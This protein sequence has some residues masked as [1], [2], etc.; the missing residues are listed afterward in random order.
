MINRF[1]SSDIRCNKQTIYLGNA[2]SFTSSNIHLTNDELM[3]DIK[4]GSLFYDHIIFSAAFFWQNKV[5]T[6]L[7]YKLEEFILHGFV[8]P[9]IRNP[10]QTNDIYD[11]ILVRQEETSKEQ[12]NNILQ[13]TGIIDEI[14]RKEDIL[15]AKRINSFKSLIHQDGLSVRDYYKILYRQDLM[16]QID[17]DSLFS[18]I[19]N[20]AMAS[21]YEKFIK[22][23]LKIMYRQDFSRSVVIAELD[24]LRINAYIIGKLVK[25]LS[26]LFLLANSRV[27]N[28]DLMISCSQ[29]DLYQSVHSNIYKGNM[30]LNQSVLLNMGIA[31]GD[32]DVLHAKDI[33]AIKSSEE[34]Q[35]FK[36]TYLNILGL[37]KYQE[38]KSIETVIGHIAKKGKIHK[39][40]RILQVPFVFLKNFSKEVATFLLFSSMGIESSIPNNTLISSG[41]DLIEKII[42]KID[43]FSTSGI[44]DFADYIVKRKYEKEVQ[45]IISMIDKGEFH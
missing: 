28:S 15:I 2:D 29:K 32:I 33:I 1:F 12:D 43:F 21:K 17:P 19:H 37:V 35:K 25:R 45:I 3:R 4:L 39:A 16:D 36:D 6:D 14:V 34:F 31:I 8:L 24:K 44:I 41:Y 27:Y 5:L 26:Y 38:E 30:Y 10:K 9:S 22:D 11:Y 18:I 23:L 40:K 20:S 7:S 42:P 13:R